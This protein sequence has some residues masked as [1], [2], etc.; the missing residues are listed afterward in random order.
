MWRAINGHWVKV[1]SCAE[2]SVLMD[3]F[4][5]FISLSTLPLALYELP[6]VIV[7]TTSLASVHDRTCSEQNSRALS[8]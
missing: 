1:P 7:V 4:T 6:G 2:M 3:F 8:E 5:M